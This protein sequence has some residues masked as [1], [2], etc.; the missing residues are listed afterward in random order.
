MQLTAPIAN[1][2]I[3]ESASGLQNF[4]QRVVLTEGRPSIVDDDPRTDRPESR[5]PLEL[6]VLFYERVRSR[7]K[8][9]GCGLRATFFKD[10][11][12]VVERTDY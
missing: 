3:E 5:D 9:L 6:L 12:L 8:D 1:V 2:S 4:L 11:V 10:Q 7:T